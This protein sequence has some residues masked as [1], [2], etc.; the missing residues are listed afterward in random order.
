[1]K[2]IANRQLQGHYGS[3]GPDQEFE[4]QDETG[5][6]LLK[7]GLVRHVRP[8]KVQYETKVITPAEAPQ[9]S[10]R[11]PFRDVPL[12]DAEQAPMDSEGNKVLSS[13][14]VPERGA[15]D[16]RGRGRGKGSD[17]E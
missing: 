4:C 13:A 5:S 7:R 14:D 17:S 10:A 8:P 11:E 9:V 12:P 1:M 3:V 15:A 16:S 6:E 2:V